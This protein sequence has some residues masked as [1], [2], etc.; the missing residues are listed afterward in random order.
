M[1]PLG[2]ACHGLPHH[3]LDVLARLQ[4]QLLAE[5]E[6]KAAEA[7][8]KS[9]FVLVLLDELAGKGHRTLVFSQSRVMLDIL[10]VHIPAY[11]R[12]TQNQGVPQN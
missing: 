5:M 1:Y 6:S 12:L 8:C 9:Q 10:Q 7:S 4:K 3:V 11:S 2:R